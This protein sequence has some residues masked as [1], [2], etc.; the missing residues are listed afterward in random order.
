MTRVSH[1]APERL[2]LPAGALP[3]QDFGTMPVEH[4]N[5]ELE[6]LPYTEPLEVVDY[7]SDND[8]L[9]IN[10]RFLLSYQLGHW[11]DTSL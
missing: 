11:S 5:C 1:A 10:P 7:H 6:T 4:A 9:E 8:D 2:Q 3:A